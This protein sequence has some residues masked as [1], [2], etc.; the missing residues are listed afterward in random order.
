MITAK[1]AHAI[2]VEK[3]M[4]TDKWIEERIIKAARCHENHCWITDT[5]LSDS[6]LDTLASNGFV[7][8]TDVEGDYKIS[9]ENETAATN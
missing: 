4:A 2:S 6:Q 1:Q 3:P 9:W 5:I 8:K 7:V